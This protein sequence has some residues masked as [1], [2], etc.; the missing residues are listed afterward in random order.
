MGS[1]AYMSPEQMRGAADVDARADI[2][3]L[4]VVLYELLTASLPF[5]GDS[6]TILITS[7][8]PAPARCAPTAPTPR[9]AS[10]RSIHR[11]LE[12]DPDR[13]FASV[14]E[15]ARALLPF[16]PP[17]AEQSLERIATVLSGTSERSSPGR[18]VVV[19]AGS[20]A[21]GATVAVTGVAARTS[22]A[23]SRTWIAI[24]VALGVVLAGGAAAYAVLRAR[25]AKTTAGP[26]DYRSVNATSTA[27]TA[28]PTAT[29]APIA[30][31]APSTTAATAAT[32]TPS[33]T[34]AP[35]ARVP[36][37]ATARAKQPPV[38]AAAKGKCTVVSYFDADGNKRFKQECPRGFGPSS[39]RSRW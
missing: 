2:W 11:C 17:R 34:A 1:P 29:A 4:G 8:P 13:R 20:D 26:A 16:A 9:A 32:E 35:T 27:V 39:R 6:V 5:D 21:T 14:A 12:K 28:A 23:R 10:R 22:A 25:P 15:L 38:P 30:T 36:V 33:A 7:V 18:R 37:G 3:S 19:G 24:P 31:A